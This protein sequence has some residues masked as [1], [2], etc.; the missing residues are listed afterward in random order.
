MDRATVRK[1]ANVDHDNKETQSNQYIH[2]LPQIERDMQHL[3]KKH[4]SSVRSGHFDVKIRSAGLLNQL[5]FHGTF[6]QYL[7]LPIHKTTAAPILTSRINPTVVYQCVREFQNFYVMRRY[8]VVVL[9]RAIQSLEETKMQFKRIGNVGPLSCAYVGRVSTDLVV[10]FRIKAVPLNLEAA[11]ENRTIRRELF[12]PFV[13]GSSRVVRDWSM[14]T[15]EFDCNQPRRL[16]I[17]EKNAGS[18][19]N[20]GWGR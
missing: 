16:T 14:R 3:Q 1:R 2:M 19:V 17:S 8:L 6:M 7:R 9:G 15:Q 11:R 10:V 5:P 12:C 20:K 13:H 18:R 4:V